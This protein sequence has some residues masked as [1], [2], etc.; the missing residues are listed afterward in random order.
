MDVLWFSFVQCIAMYDDDFKGVGKQSKM[1]TKDK[2]IVQ[3]KNHSF[4]RYKML[5][6]PFRMYWL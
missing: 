3:Q 1:W 2:I 5:Q 6:S 4:E